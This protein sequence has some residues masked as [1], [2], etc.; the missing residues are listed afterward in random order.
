MSTLK[1]GGFDSLEI[2]IGDVDDI[3]IV[4]RDGIF[5]INEGGLPDGDMGL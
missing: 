4:I 5:D 2:I 1:D 3:F